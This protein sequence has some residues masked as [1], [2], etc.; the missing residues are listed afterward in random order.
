MRVAPVI[1]Q[2]NDER[3][4][5]TKL[6][7]SRLPSV[8]LAQRARTTLLPAEGMQGKDI[9]QQFGMNHARVSRCCKRYARLPEPATRTRLEAAPAT[10]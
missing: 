3:A 8:E 2:A 4:V 10:V 5:L 1:V 6:M 7:C 9:A